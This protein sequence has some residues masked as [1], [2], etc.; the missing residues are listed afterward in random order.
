MSARAQAADALL[1]VGQREEAA[2]MLTRVANNPHGGAYV[3]RARA[4]LDQ[5][6]A[7]D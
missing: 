2:A 7:S 5:F 1:H 3:E 6:I 4:L